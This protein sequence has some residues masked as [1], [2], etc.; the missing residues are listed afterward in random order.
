[1][2]IR[3]KSKNVFKDQRLLNTVLKNHYMRVKF[4]AFKRVK[5]TTATAGGAEASTINPL[6]LRHDYRYEDSL[7][8]LCALIER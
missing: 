6:I 8:V 3:S 2:I 1:M 4:T 7:C 5:G